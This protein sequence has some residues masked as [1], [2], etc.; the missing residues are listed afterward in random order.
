MNISMQNMGIPQSLARPA[1]RFGMLEISEAM[2]TDRKTL[3]S[4]IETKLGTQVKVSYT[5]GGLSVSF[6]PKP[7]LVNAQSRT[8]RHN[9]YDLLKTLP[10]VQQFEGEDPGS[11]D[12]I[13]KGQNENKYRLDIGYPGRNW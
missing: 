11:Y 6:Q 13:F 9:L 5:H 8:P 10:S 3:I 2:V 7:E 1:V 4:E 12:L